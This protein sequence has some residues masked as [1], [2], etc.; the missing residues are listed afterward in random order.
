MMSL[1]LLVQMASLNVSF[2]MANQTGPIS[3]IF[4]SPTRRMPKAMATFF[5]VFLFVWENSRL[6]VVRYCLW[7]GSINKGISR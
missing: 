5:C 4:N 2:L 6:S 7:T 3:A 1:I